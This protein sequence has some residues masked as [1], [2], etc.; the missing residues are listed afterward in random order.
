MYLSAS[1][2]SALFARRV[3]YSPQKR[4]ASFIFIRSSVRRN[5]ASV[6]SRHFPVLCSAT[7]PFES[8][9]SERS[10][11][12]R[13]AK[14]TRTERREGQTGREN[15]N[16]GSLAAHQHSWRVMRRG[17][18]IPLRPPAVAAAAARWML[19]M[20]MQPRITSGGNRSGN[21]AGIGME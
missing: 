16:R 17:E 6:L 19:F 12:R 3:I 14:S 18:F 21:Y 10:S 2:L 9:I 20:Q 5:I 4:F 1:L 7:S 15:K 13:R 11:E 8:D